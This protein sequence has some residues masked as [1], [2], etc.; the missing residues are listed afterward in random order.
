MPSAICFR[1]TRT[2]AEEIERNFLNKVMLYRG[3]N[4]ENLKEPSKIS[5]REVK[6]FNIVGNFWC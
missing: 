6:I 5:E 4:S 1:T 2:E 3:K